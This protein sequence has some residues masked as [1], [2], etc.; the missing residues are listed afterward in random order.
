MKMRQILASF[1]LLGFILP[2]AHAG[3]TVPPVES[4]NATGT[5]T[6][7]W[8]PPD[9]PAD[10]LVQATYLIYGKNLT[11][12]EETYL[13]NQTGAVFAAQVAGG[14]DAYGVA[15]RIGT[16]QSVTVY[17][18]ASVKLEPPFVDMRCIKIREP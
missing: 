3:E 16:A 4:V 7:T 6:V 1:L 5:G 14:F 2:P 11:T 15:V 9:L 10:Q 8:S 17:Q 18:C 12:G 13:G